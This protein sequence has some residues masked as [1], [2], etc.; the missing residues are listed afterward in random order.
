MWGE[1]QRGYKKF[2]LEYVF[3][4]MREIQ[5]EY[6]DCSQIVFSGSRQKSEELIPKILVLGKD[7]WE[8]DVQYFWN[9]QLKKDGLARRQT[10][11]KPR[12]QGYKPAN[13]R[14]MAF[15]LVRFPLYSL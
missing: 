14:S 2:N 7:L 6:T 15:S 12:V 5:A 10:K 9:Q 13:S 3:H 1:N 11:T 4:R 8:V